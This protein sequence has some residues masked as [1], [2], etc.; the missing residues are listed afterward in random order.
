[1]G[2]IPETTIQEIRDRADI[3]GLIGRYVELKQAGRNW[4][5]LCPFHDEKTPSFNVNPDRQIFHC[6][7]C[8]K[9]GNVITFLVEHD[10]LTFPEAVRTLAD[11]LGI[12]VP[13]TGG[14]SERGEGERVF[15]ALEIAQRCFREALHSSQGTAA[16]DYLTQRGLDA[17]VIEHF[18]LGFVPDRWDTV[19]RALERASVPIRVGIAA[20]LL[21]EGKSGGSYDYLR[22]RVTFPIRDVRGR[23]IAFGGRALGDEEGPKYLNTPESSVY[24]KR[25]TFYGFP[26]ALEPIRKQRRVVICEGYFDAIALHR[27]GVAEAVATCGTALTPDHA[28]ELRRRRVGEV[29]LLFD[30]DSAGQHAMQRALEILL[31]V[32]LRVRAVVLPA[33]Q[34]PDDYLA[35]H[36]AEPLRALIDAAPDAVELVLRHAMMGG[37]S[38]PN[39]KADVVRHM[40][41]LIAAIA[42][43]IERAEYTRRLAVATGTDPTAVEAVV[44]ASIRGQSVPAD[45]DV[46]NGLIRPRSAGAD[47][48]HVR[49]IALILSHEPSVV[50][51]ELCARMH[52]VLPECAWK[53]MVFLLVDAAA[54]GCVD[55][56]GAIDHLAIQDRLDADSMKLLSELMVDD[57]MLDSE[58]P[59]GDVLVQLVV[60]Y[61][62]KR[63][64]ERQKELTRRTTD[65]E[66]DAR[67]I[68]E[69]KQA[70]LDRKRAAAGIGT[71]MAP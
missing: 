2:R 29:I 59:A 15:D 66:E 54:D 26:H 5:G 61:E 31:R 20:G 12:E 11:D 56:E 70:L 71:G 3:V 67:R 37:C 19:S 18:G 36:G 58:M 17:D 57:S 52:E 30:G 45:H 69:E 65:P 16:L 44:R 7:G 40:A 10:N 28:D 33:G 24:H 9:G 62:A 53:D 51:D 4:K 42:G 8:E 63:L 25:R 46:A 60:R 43:P 48:R 32:D 21:G 6:F 49:Q 13:E 41:P 35:S 1:L 68:L 34:D 27:A 38:T 23:V 22:G 64:A 14:R 47:D 39:Q 55:A 50:T